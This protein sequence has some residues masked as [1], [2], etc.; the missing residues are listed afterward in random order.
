MRD[1]PPARF[2]GGAGTL[3]ACLQVQI[4]EAFDT[5]PDFA[6]IDMIRI[7]FSRCRAAAPLL[8]ACSVLALMGGTQEA[9]AEIQL[10]FSLA[11]HHAP[12]SDVTYNFG[13]GEGSQT[14]TVGWDG[15]N[16]KMPPNFGLRATWWF[17]DKPNWGIGIDNVHTK[18]AADPMPKDFKRLEFTDGINMITLTGN[19]RYLNETRW[20]PYGAAGVGITTPH[21]EATSS[22]GSSDMFAYQ[23]GGPAV[24]MTFGVDFEINDR[25]SVF[26]EAKAA[27]YWF[28]VDLEGDGTLQS[29][30]FGY[31]LAV[32]VTYSLKDGF[33][34]G[35]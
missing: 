8:T 35:L 34:F 7:L 24:Q 14:E 27:Q 23:Y 2:E 20:T 11:N 12:R 10:S 4:F 6:M 32:G 19:Y 29:D 16:L 9:D 25:W 26:G 15:E 21:V 22:D 3:F 17:E 28:D 1:C 33:R 13:Q 31:V 18:I 30:V 5:G